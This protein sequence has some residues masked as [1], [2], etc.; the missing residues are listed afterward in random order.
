MAVPLQ[1]LCTVV[2]VLLQCIRP[3]VVPP[4]EYSVQVYL[5]MAGRQ[6]DFVLDAFQMGY[7]GVNPSIA[8]DPS[9]EHRT[10]AVWRKGRE[11]NSKVGYVWFDKD[12][13]PLKDVGTIGMLALLES[14]C[15]I[16]LSHMYYV[17][18]EELEPNRTQ[19][20]RSELTGEDTRIFSLNGAITLAYNVHHGKYKTFH[21]AQL[22]YH[23]RPR[24]LPKTSTGASLWSV[25]T[26]N[27]EICYVQSDHQ[28]NVVYEEGSEA[29][30]DRHQKN[31]SPFEFC[32]LCTYTHVSL[33]VPRLL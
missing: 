15:L 30:A 27:E 28:H 16:P 2:I 25:I 12:W 14:V 11:R 10:V 13:N 26:N 22:H 20:H 5:D 8:R 33:A 6:Q 7:A 24:F 9:D 4:D 29:S 32:P 1:L 21:Y 31:W 18:L 17:V 23:Q 19:P 3:I